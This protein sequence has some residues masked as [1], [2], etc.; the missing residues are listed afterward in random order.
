MQ[1]SPYKAPNASLGVETVA[2]KESDFV[3]AFLCFA[4]SAVIAGAINFVFRFF[5]KL[6]IVRKLVP[7]SHAAA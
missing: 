1:S 2:P 6:F 4:V 5:V 3:K 7:S